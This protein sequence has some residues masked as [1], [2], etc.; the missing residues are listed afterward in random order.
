MK[1]VIKNR[2]YDTESAKKLADYEPS[3]NRSDFHWYK[4]SLYL[5]KTGEFFLCGEGNAASKYRKAVALN[6]WCPAEKIIPLTYAEA[7]AWAE[8]NLDG[9][10]YIIIFGEPTED[11]SRQT[12]SLSLSAQKVAQA[13]QAAAKAGI[14]LSAYIENLIK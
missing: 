13:K 11:S 6:E 1:K 4:E 14:S 10:E 12:I 5:K 7:Q 3:S 8:E 9:D 2:V